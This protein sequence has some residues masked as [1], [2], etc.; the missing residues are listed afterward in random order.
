MAFCCFLYRVT[1]PKVSRSQKLLLIANFYPN[2]CNFSRYLLNQYFREFFFPFF[3]CQSFFFAFPYLLCI[4]TMKVDCNLCANR[5]GFSITSQPFLITL[6]SF[7]RFC[8]WRWKSIALCIII[9]RQKGKEYIHFVREG[10][11]K[12]V[13]IL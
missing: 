11:S 2:G 3:R 9:C 10:R 4:S 6:T 1:I 13:K 12:K 7:L 5:D 8:I